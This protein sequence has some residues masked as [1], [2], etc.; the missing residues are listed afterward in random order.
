VPHAVYSPDLAPS[1]FFL[2]RYLT[3]KLTAFHC[4]TLDELKNAIIT[5]FNEIDR[6]TLLAVFNSWFERLEWGIQ[7]GGNTSLSKKKFNIYIFQ[8][9]EKRGGDGLMD[10]PIKPE[11]FLAALVGQHRQSIATPD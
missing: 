1:D 10:P 7:H 5:I 9:T 3:A 11:V 8:L 4:T 2:L 6:V